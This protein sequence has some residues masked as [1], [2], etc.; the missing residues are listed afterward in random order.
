MTTSIFEGFRPAAYPYRFDVELV[1]GTLA[2]G[3]PTDPK[4]AE[5]WLKTKL[6]LDP[7]RPAARRGGEGHGR[8][9]RH[10]HG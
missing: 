10:R 5:G 7:R 6:G 1:I 4:V 9:R 3:T 2:G 8:A